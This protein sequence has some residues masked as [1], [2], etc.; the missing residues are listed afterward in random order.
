MSS[1]INIQIDWADLDLFGHVNNVAFFR[2]MQSAR[3][4]YCEQIGL[5]SLNEAGKLSFLVASSRCD[6]R[7]AIYYPGQVEITSSIIWAR[8]TSFC[9]KHKI[10]DREQK[11]YAEGEDVLVLYDYQRAEKC[12]IDDQLRQRM[13]LPSLNEQR[14]DNS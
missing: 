3:L 9:L 14:R 4:R 6:F 13:G 2:Y 10:H 8:N 11:I 1:V 12:I 7:N 5:S